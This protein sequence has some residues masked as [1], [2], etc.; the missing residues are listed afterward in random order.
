MVKVRE[1]QR[2][3]NKAVYLVLGVTMEG[4]KE[5]LRMWMSEHEGAKFWLTV[6]T[7]LQNRGMKDGFIGGKDGL[8]GLPEA[9]ET[10]FPHTRVQ[11]CMVHLVRNSLKYVSYKHRFAVAAD[12][13]AIYS[14]STE[15]EAE[16]HLELKASKWDRQYPTTSLVLA[17]AVGARDPSVCLLR[18][19][20]QGDLHHQCHRVRQYDPAQGHAHSPNFPFR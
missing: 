9:I 6:F 18:G 14:A 5:R 19:Y 3:V 11:L 15:A 2:V 17:G 13:K 20:S 1:N 8:T 7:E 16:F 4:Q 10:A 12:L